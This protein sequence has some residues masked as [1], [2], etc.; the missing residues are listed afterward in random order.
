MEVQANK[1]V[2]KLDLQEKRYSATIKH[3]VCAASRLLGYE[4]SV[5]SLLSRS[6]L[7]KYG[8]IINSVRIFHPFYILG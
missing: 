2:V 8:N 1:N 3:R 4:T 5:Q 7:G 6:H